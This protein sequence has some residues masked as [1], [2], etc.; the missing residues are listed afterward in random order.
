MVTFERSISALNFAFPDSIVTF[1]GFD[2]IEPLDFIA[3][4]R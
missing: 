2:N 1:T 4:L 3:P